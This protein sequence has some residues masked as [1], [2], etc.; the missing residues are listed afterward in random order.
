MLFYYMNYKPKL[1]P[2]STGPANTSKWAL[3]C[4][5]GR[6]HRH[7][8]GNHQAFSMGQGEAGVKFLSH[9]SMA[10]YLNDKETKNI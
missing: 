2:S 6:P 5:E 7:P 10:W 3:I 8:I 4:L 1:L 9:P